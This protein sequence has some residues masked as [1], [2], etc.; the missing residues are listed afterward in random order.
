MQLKHCKWYTLSFARLTTACGAIPVSS[1]ECHVHPC[2][3]QKHT[4]LAVCTFG[5]GEAFVEIFFTVWL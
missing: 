4:L 3:V 5:F 2:L 1:L